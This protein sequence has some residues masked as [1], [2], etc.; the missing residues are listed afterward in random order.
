ME[1][2][3]IE[4]FEVRCE[5]DGL[6]GVPTIAMGQPAEETTKKKKSKI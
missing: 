4:S 1:E 3:N 6:N 5:L 2:K